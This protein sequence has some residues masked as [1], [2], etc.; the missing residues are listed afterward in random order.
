[1]KTKIF[2]SLFCITSIVYSQSANQL[3]KKLQN[4]FNSITNFTAT[5][6][7]NSST[8][9]GQD[10]GKT[11]GNFTYKKKNK[12][13]V[14]LKNQT[15]VSDGQTIW[16]SDKRFN[17]VVISNLSDD[18]T[19]FSLER[20][21]FDY[22][23]LCKIKIAKDD[24]LSKGDEY[25]ELTPKDQ[26]MEFKY[27]KIWLTTDGM[28]SKLE[29]LDLGDIRYA[30]Q[31]NDLKINQDISEARFTFYPPKGIKIIDLR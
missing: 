15:I 26:D 12:F 28:I 27:V 2:L 6:S 13:V 1:M 31:F 9:Q 29:V 19:S 10:Q 17:R 16:N 5:F 8:T 18:P 22:P 7:Q 11:S 4:K 30:F 23:P 24:A 20:F 3:I 21:V 14:E 25:I